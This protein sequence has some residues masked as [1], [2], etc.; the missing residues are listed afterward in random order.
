MLD[1]NQINERLSKALNGDESFSDLAE[2]LSREAASLRFEDK[3][4]LDLADAILQPLEVYFDGVINE[5][6]LRIELS[7]LVPVNKTLKA[8]AQFISFHDVG[9][10]A[11]VRQP[12][13][14]PQVRSEVN[15]ILHSGVVA[16]A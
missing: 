2:W 15:S 10:H 1:A 7:A 16:L 5:A 6:E 4:L 12:V 11:P 14:K 13:P 9:I 3:G 8:T